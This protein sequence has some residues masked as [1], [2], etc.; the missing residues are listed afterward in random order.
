M[1]D[2]PPRTT[3]EAQQRLN[4]AWRDLWVGL[5]NTTPGYYLRV[6]ADRLAGIPKTEKEKMM[7]RSL[8]RPSYAYIK[9]AKGLCWAICVFVLCG[10]EI[11]YAWAVRPPPV[12]LL[13]SSYLVRYRP[14]E[15]RTL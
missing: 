12:M 10:A 8:S 1:S 3:R 2:Q 13:V 15:S 9:D 11:H 6:L 7:P 14:C 5:L 4:A